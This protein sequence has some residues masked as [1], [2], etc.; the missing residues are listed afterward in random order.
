MAL[1]CPQCGSSV[2]DGAVRCDHCPAVFDKPGGWKPVLKR[3]RKESSPA[4]LIL[5]LG[6]AAVAIPASGFGLAAL[7]TLV[8]PGCH[9]NE[10]GGCHGCGANDLLSFL[11][12]GGFVGAL[13]A[14]MT[15]LPISIV[16]AG[17][18]ALFTRLKSRPHTPSKSSGLS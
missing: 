18:V 10:A 13:A 6:V 17:I 4:A 14:F 16:V 1:Y 15:I 5:K 9:C 3:P 11:A 8:I 12:F 2:E 7:A